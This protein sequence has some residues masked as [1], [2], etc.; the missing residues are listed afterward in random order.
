MLYRHIPHIEQPVSLLGFGNFTF[1][2]NWWGDITDDEAVHLQ[3]YAVERGV[4]F[5]DS[6]PAYGEGRAESLLSRTIRDVGRDRL[7]IATK[8]GYDITASGEGGSGS[9]R[10]RPQDFSPAAIRRELE[11]SLQRLGVNHIDLYQAHNLKLPQW[12]DDLRDTIEQLMD[13][14]KIGAWGVALGPAIGW[15]EE[16]LRAWDEGA[17]VVQTVMNLYEQDPGRELCE[18]ADGGA[19]IARVPTNSGMLDEEFS[20]AGYRFD[21]KDHRKFRDH[22]WLVYG[23][24]K[25]RIVKPLADDCGCS[26]R[27][28]AFRWLLSQPAMASIEPNILNRGDVDDFADAADQGR[29]PDDVMTRLAELYET[30]FDLGD[31]AHPCD[32]KSSVVEGGRVRSGRDVVTTYEHR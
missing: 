25:N 5:F 31:D 29:L 15:R 30:D 1:G 6:A 9:H 11:G 2:A 32:L 21:P 12:P 13:E 17:D 8:F 16:G 4:N 24:E 3:N 14:G 28:F 10:E 22:H 27:Q 26:L 18:A 7:V 20:D 19:V 23:L